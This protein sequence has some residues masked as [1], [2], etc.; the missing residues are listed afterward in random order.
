MGAIVNVYIGKIPKIA[1]AFGQM[2]GLVLHFD[3]SVPEYGEAIT[4]P[5]GDTMVSDGTMVAV[6]ISED[7]TVAA[8]F[9]IPADVALALSRGIW[10]AARHADPQNTNLIAQLRSSFAGNA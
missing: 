2:G 7:E 5:G 9:M 1:L 8:A 4:I 3:V 10:T 6:T